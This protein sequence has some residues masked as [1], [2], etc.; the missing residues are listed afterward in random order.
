[1]FAY[2]PTER[3]L[4]DLV[5]DALDDLEQLEGDRDPAADAAAVLHSKLLLHGRRH[6]LDANSAEREVVLR[7][8]PGTALWL[9]ELVAAGWK[10]KGR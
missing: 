3:S 4:G 8:P 5:E 7:I 6:H 2:D 9:A 10:P 1:M